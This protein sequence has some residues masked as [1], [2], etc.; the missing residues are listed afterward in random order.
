MTDDESAR[1]QSIERIQRK[2]RFW[3]QTIAGGIGMLLLAVIWAI[4]EF[5]NAAG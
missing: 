1:Q 2:R 5:Q 4:T 3:Y